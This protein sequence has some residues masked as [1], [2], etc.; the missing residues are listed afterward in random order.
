MSVI[1]ALIGAVAIAVAA[2]V[3]AS[4][5]IGAIG[6]AQQHNDPYIG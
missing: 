4:G 1:A 2:P 5:A 6:V 3:I